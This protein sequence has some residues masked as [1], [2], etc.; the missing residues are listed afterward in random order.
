[1]KSE[2][3]SSFQDME[4]D[5][6]NKEII[7]RKIGS[8]ILMKILSLTSKFSEKQGGWEV[9]GENNLLEIVIEFPLYRHK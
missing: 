7:L 2:K 4:I 3:L 9:L 8:L 6:S 1:V 5:L